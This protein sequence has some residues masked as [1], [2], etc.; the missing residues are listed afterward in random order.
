MKDKFWDKLLL[1]MGNSQNIPIGLFDERRICGLAMFSRCSQFYILL[2]C[3]F[4]LYMTK[5][6]TI[7]CVTPVA[8]NNETANPVSFKGSVATIIYILSYIFFLL[9]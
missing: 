4:P 3:K 5:L 9:K 2:Y 6:N 7:D 1:Y 8:E